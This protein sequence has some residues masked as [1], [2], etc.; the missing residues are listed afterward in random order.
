MNPS[1]RH[2]F[3]DS[4]PFEE[5]N[6]RVRPKKSTTPPQGNHQN[7]QGQTEDDQPEEGHAPTQ[8]AE[9]T[10]RADTSRAGSQAGETPRVRTPAG[11]DSRAQGPEAA[12]HPGKKGQGQAPGYLC[13]MR[14]SPHP[15]RDPVPD[16]LQAPPG[17]PKAG[18]GESCPEKGAGLRS[19]PH[20]LTTTPL[21]GRGA[22]SRP[23]TG[24]DRD[25]LCVEGLKEGTRKKGNA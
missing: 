3:V 14:G 5:P 10:G 23:V 11:P 18:Q 9:A 22:S 8:D 1:K 6:R 13:G 2:I 19:N 21:T 17:V 7:P 15:G 4:F 24:A 12:Q 25:V 16:L 20:L